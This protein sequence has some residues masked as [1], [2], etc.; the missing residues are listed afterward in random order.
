MFIQSPV[1][2]AFK[3][4]LIGTT[5]LSGLAFAPLSWADVAPP[6][7]HIE[8]AQDHSDLKADPNVTFGRLANGMGYIIQKNASPAGTAS[9]RLYIGAGSMMEA[10]DQQGLAHFIEHM[11]FRGS[12]NVGA[13]EFVKILERHGLKFGPDTNAFTSFDQTVYQLDLPRTDGDYLDT[14]FFL[15]HETAANVTFDPKAVDDERNVVLSEE[16]LR[17]TPEYRAEI[18][19]L[20]TA[21]P[22]QLMPQRLPIGK[23]DV[24]KSAPAQRLKDYYNQYYRPQNAVLVFVGDVDPAKIEARIKSTFSDWQT[25]N[26]APTPEFGQYKPKGENAHTYSEGGLSNG[27]QLS[28]FSPVDPSFQDKAHVIAL[29]KRSLA[30]G[31]LNQRLERAAKKDGSAFV[32]AC[33]E[34]SDI[35]KTARVVNF[36]I[37][38]K[39]GLTDKALEQAYG[40]LHQYIEFGPQQAELD[41]LI[42]NMDSAN[43]AAA[44][45]E[46]TRDTRELAD[47]LTQQVEEKSVISSP[48][49]DLEF[50]KSVKPQLTLAAVFETVKA[51]FAGDGPLISH[52][53]PD[54]AASQKSKDE[55]SL[56]AEFDTLKSA[57]VVAAEN[58]VKKP[59]T[60]TDFGKASPVIK[61]SAVTDLEAR[62]FV[63]ANGVRLTIKPTKF[64]DNRVLVG[65]SLPG[66]KK[67]VSPD[68]AKI[69]AMAGRVGLFDGGLGKLDIDELKDTLAGKV[70]SLSLGLGEDALVLSGA[71]T[72][73]DLLTQMQVLAA[74]MTDPAYR[75]QGLDRLKAA[76]PDI[77]TQLKATTSGVFSMNAAARLYDNDPRFAFPS[78]EDIQSTKNEALKAWLD[79]QIKTAPIDITIVGDVTEAQA[80]KVMEATFAG[81]AKRPM[82][83]SEPVF[84]VKFPKAHLEQ[85]FEHEGRA[86]QSLEFTAFPTQGYYKDRKVARGLEMLSEVMALRLTDEVRVKRALSYSPFAFSNPSAAFD[87]Y[88]YIAAQSEIKPENHAAYLAVLK[89]IISDLKAHP[90]SQDELLRARKPAIDKLNA[91]RKSNEYWLRTLQGSGLDP[92]RLDNIRTRI[93][94]LMAITPE[95]LQALAKT[96]LDFD[97]ALQIRIKPKAK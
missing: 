53:A 1:K 21:F 91:E 22:G 93:P 74:F 16:R 61:S 81:L 97:K 54:I 90:I 63:F 78:L 13:N 20:K 55:A 44:K 17:D 2:M 82:A 62:Q 42:A 92:K 48:S 65:I 87:T 27:L 89:D 12:K 68:Q 77:F 39:P 49:Q 18:D 23:V 95:D 72:R 59:W 15:L 11:T 41:R 69:A 43:E 85:D 47:Q 30:I 52:T 57:P 36:S 8:F 80:L 9:M 4:L 67:I 76:A 64:E 50:Y 60:Y 7:S 46:K 38:P 35:E 51:L 83:G 31:I 96:Y 24:I 34:S 19:W 73:D 86:D 25:T 88:G 45:G 10:D 66:G 28:W 70:Y 94:Q 26:P 75:P 37:T 84:G 79:H 29:F 40:L 56:T 58:R 71:T 14:A 6:L 33:V 5:L 32:S 3:S